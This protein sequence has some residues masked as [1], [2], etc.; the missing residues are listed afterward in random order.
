MAVNISSLPKFTIFVLWFSLQFYNFGNFIFYDSTA[1]LAVQLSE[2]VGL[3]PNQVQFLTTIYAIPNVVLPFICGSIIDLYGLESS[4]F[5]GNTMM[6]LS[7]VVF[8]YGIQLK[9]WGF[10]ILGRFI[11]A[12]CA[13]YNVITALVLTNNVVSKDWV[14]QNFAFISFLEN[15]SIWVNSLMCSIVLH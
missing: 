4:Q 13:E 11:F 12:L 2:D 3:T 1:I 14:S 6:G 5:V 8:Y 9:S 10:I 7:F 15:I